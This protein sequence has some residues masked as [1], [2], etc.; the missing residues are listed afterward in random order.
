M[1]DT[2]DQDLLNRLN[3]LR[4]S[5][6]TLNPNKASFPPASTSLADID[7]AS[8]FARLNSNSPGPQQHQNLSLTSEPDT[9]INGEDEQS[10]EELLASLEASHD[11]LKASKTDAEAA[12]DLIQQARAALAISGEAGADA[13][14]HG[15]QTNE[16]NVMISEEHEDETIQ[17]TEDEE[18]DEYIQIALAAVKLDEAEPPVGPSR[19]VDG[20]DDN[21]E[22]TTELPSAP[23]S[24][25]RASP[26]A[27]SNGFLPSA[28]TFAPL[29][30]S[31]A[32]KATQK[33]AD[34]DIE[35]WCIICSDDAT[36]RC[37]GCDGDLYCG[38][39]W[40]EGHRGPDAGYEEKMHKAVA[41]VKNGKEEKQK[42]RRMVG[43]A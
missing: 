34:E 41:Y 1:P 14:A 17:R 11:P 27:E 15:C 5:T 18:A 23:T 22:T 19:D 13:G 2:R 21:A 6:I 39:C 32:A 10:L 43:A 24:S 36:V 40:N 31:T 8:R 12:Q 4:P 30:R 3:A 38:N 20:D 7:L 35:T 25:L 26:Q 37:L 33:F 28:P 29:T 9:E 42:K 16:G